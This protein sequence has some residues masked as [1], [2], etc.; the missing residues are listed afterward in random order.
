MH[1]VDVALDLVDALRRDV[2]EVRS[3]GKPAAQDAVAVL[4]VALLVGVVG[5][6][7]VDLRVEGLVQD[8]LVEE[9][10][11]VVRDDAANPADAPG[12]PDTADARHF[13][14]F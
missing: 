14:F 13:P 10:A 11:A 3:F 2:A 12:S 4:H 7:V 9:F 1:G 5:P 6:R 8:I